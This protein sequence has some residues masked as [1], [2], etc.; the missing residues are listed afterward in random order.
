[1][2][3]IFLSDVAEVDASFWMVMQHNF[4]FIFGIILAVFLAKKSLRV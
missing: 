3:N 1:M 2:L 4:I